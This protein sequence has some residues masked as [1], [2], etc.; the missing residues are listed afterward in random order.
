MSNYIYHFNKENMRKILRGFIAALG[1]SYSD[2]VGGEDN[3]DEMEAAKLI[4]H[5]ERVCSSRDSER[6]LLAVTSDIIKYLEFYEIRPKPEIDEF[7]LIY[8]IGAKLA[9]FLEESEYY[10]A[11]KL[12]WYATV[13]LLDT[14]LKDVTNGDGRPKLKCRLKKVITDNKLNERMGKDGIYLVYKCSFNMLK[15][16]RLSGDRQAA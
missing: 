10:K 6:I 14:R 3:I 2:Y 12:V 11:A 16:A 15:E 7:K 8:F 5:I 1:D 13:C 4:D 9:F